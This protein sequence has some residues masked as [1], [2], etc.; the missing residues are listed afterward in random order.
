MLASISPRSIAAA[1]SS[2]PHR[3][4]G[5]LG[6]TM[7]PR[8]EDEHDAIKRKDRVPRTRSRGLEQPKRSHQTQERLYPPA[9]CC[10]LDYAAA[11]GDIDDFASKLIRQGFDGAKMQVLGDEG[12]GS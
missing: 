6:R 2:S 3:G 4:I 1:S 9:L 8:S 12:F 7:T 5:D 11:L 10:Q